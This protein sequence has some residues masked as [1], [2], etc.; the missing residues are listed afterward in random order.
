[1]AAA[2]EQGAV[3][4]EGQQGKGLPYYNLAEHQCFYSYSWGPNGHPEMVETGA[5]RVECQEEGIQ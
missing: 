4:R 1:M 2:S 3:R 5:K